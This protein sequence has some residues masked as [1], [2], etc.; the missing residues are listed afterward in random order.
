VLL[1][2]TAIIYAVAVPE[3]MAQARE[4][5]TETLQSAVVYLMAGALYLCMTI[6]MA[7]IA[8]RLERASRAWR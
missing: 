8:A 6:P 2:D 5:V 1:K 4:L 7:R 3:I